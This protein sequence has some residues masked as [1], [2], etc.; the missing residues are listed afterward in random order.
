LLFSSVKNK[1]I[2][3]NRRTSCL[4]LPLLALGLAVPFAPSQEA[5]EQIANR[6]KVAG[7][8]RLHL[9]ERKAAAPGGGQF[10][11]V[12]RTV[13]WNASE[14]AII[15]CDMWD[16]HYCKSSAQRVGVMVPKMNQ[17]LTAAR[18]HGVMII[19][20]P[21]GTMDIYAGTPY[22]QRMQQA[23]AAQPPAPIASWCNL[24][25]AK[26]PPMPVDTAKCA[27]DDPVVGP[28]VRKYSRQH[29]GLDIIGYDGISDSGQ[30]IFNW[31][32]QEGIT[33]I[34][35]LGVHTNMCVLGR[36]F[37]IRQLVR[38]GRNVALVRD[39]TDAMYDPR[40]PPYVSHARGTELVVEH[41]EAYW[42]PSILSED[43][44]R[45]VP[46]S[47]GPQKE[48]SLAPASK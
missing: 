20:A 38:L 40:Q 36:S 39:L 9:S 25:P 10:Q 11:A 28:A 21:S 48:Q 6:P 22:R 4:L 24:D 23:K 5:T 44:T 18:S 32:A 33:N 19:H 30:E 7:K 35:I 3:M 1:E 31:C 46:G 43:L 34:A 27:C 14:T 47:A 8:L 26:E 45:V 16:D 37:G 42:C 2:A 12:E 13:D 15:V 41:I 17:V 29:A